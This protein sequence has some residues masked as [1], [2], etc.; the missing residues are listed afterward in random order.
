MHVLIDWITVLDE[1][2]FNADAYT[3]S[4]ALVF[5]ANYFINKIYSLLPCNIASSKHLESW[6]NTWVALGNP[7]AAPRVS[8][9]DLC[10]PNLPHV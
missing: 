4:P 1:S 6:E 5:P 3:S 9:H 8:Q 10:S 2:I 7:S